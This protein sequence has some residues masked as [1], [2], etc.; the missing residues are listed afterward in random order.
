MRLVTWNLR[1][2]NPDDGED[3]W[4]AR[5]HLVIQMLR[6]LRAD[7]LGA[8]EVLPSMR[9]DL[10]ALLPDLRDV[11][12]PRRPGDEGSPLFF[13]RDGFDLVAAGTFWLSP[14]P[15]RA[16]SRGWDAALPRIATWAVLR[17]RTKAGPVIGVFNTHLD[18]VGETARIQ[19]V[20]VILERMGQ[21]AP[22]VDGL[23]L[24]GDFNA[25]PE[26]PP[27]KTV[28]G[29]EFR[30]ANGAP[31]RLVSAYE[32]AGLSIPGPTFHGF[33]RVRAGSGPIDHVYVSSNLAIRGV[34]I[35]TDT[36]EGRYPS[37][38]YPVAVEISESERSGPVFPIG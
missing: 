22:A 37:D 14:T 30:L 24:L 10:I 27:L 8:Q 21:V 15:D 36:F 17:A 7:V 38:H 31:A 4:P 34:E 18:H 28:V 3:A 29:W 23:V 9:D 1:F 25:E 2:D 19:G 33:G 35:G 6:H 13:R 12:E 20:S 11:G 5:K 32:R 16:G 26:T